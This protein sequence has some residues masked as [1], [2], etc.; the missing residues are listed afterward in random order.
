MLCCENVKGFFTGMGLNNGV[1]CTAENGFK[2][3]YI[4]G[5]IINSKNLN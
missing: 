2:R 4:G 5:N 3:D 1:I